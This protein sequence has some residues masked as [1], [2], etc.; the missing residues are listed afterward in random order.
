MARDGAQYVCQSC[1]AV[2]TRWGGQ[3]PACG[4][5]NTLVEEITSRPPGALKPAS[6]ARKSRLAFEG[7]DT[8]TP[9]PPRL[10]TGLGEWDRVCGGGVAP[11]SAILVGG[12]PGVGKS[13]LLL[14]VAA[15]AARAG[16][17]CAYISGEEAVE[18]VRAWPT[19]P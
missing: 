13:T 18:Q 1:G 4:A 3:C 17:R 9:S 6:A 10:V 5:W 12:D 2:Q 19:R 8:Q 16:A 11:G 15:S 7:L 14:Q